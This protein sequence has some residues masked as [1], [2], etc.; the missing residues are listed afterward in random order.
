MRFFRPLDFKFAFGSPKIILLFIFRERPEP[1]RVDFFKTNFLFLFFFP[2]KFYLFD[3]S[4][5]DKSRCAVKYV[6][7]RTTSRT[8]IFHFDRLINNYVFI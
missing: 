3:S 1:P 7:L 2:R 8:L 5:I 4:N 6:L